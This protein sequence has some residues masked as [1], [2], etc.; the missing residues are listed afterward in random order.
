MSNKETKKV[1]L[2]TE[3][4]KIIEF[5]GKLIRDDEEELDLHLTRIE[6]LRHHLLHLHLLVIKEELLVAMEA[7]KDE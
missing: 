1:K 2:L 4:Q 3:R 5:F 6:P 7:K